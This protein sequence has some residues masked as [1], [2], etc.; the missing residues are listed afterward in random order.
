M[1]VLRQIN[2]FDLLIL[3][4]GISLALAIRF[5]LLDFKSIDYFK[6]T[7][8][9]YNTIKTN[10]FSAFSQNFSNY[11]PPYLY[12]LYLLARFFPDVP[13]LYATKIPSLIADFITALFAYLI[14]RLKYP[15]SP[16]PIFAGFAILFAPTVILNSAFWGQADALYTSVLVVSIYFV[17][18]KK[19]GLSM[20]FF[21]VSLAFK[22]QAAF[23]LPL[24][25]A[26]FLRKEISW[27]YFL[28]IP[29]I[30]F[31]ALLP[32]WVAGR[33]LIDLLLIYPS[34]A[35]QY[36]QLSMHAA[37]IFSWLPNGGRFFSYFYTA[38]LIFA[39]ATGIF[40]SIIVYNSPN[41]VQQDI[42]LELAF[43]TVLLMPFV[44]PTMHER[45]FYPADVISIIFAFYF[46][47]FFFAPILMSVVSFFSY[48]PTLFNVEPVPISVLAVCIL[49]LI[50]IISR[51]A[52]QKLFYR[53][54]K[55]EMLND[56]V[57]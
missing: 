57:K 5:S 42:L 38:G 40:Y 28:L 14:V 55:S 48:Q 49:I 31:L 41:E 43:I 50:L 4:I 17:L 52:I 11:N 29:A 20:V 30:L 21:G 7:K 53:D 33:S 2:Y 18:T 39:A 26:L 25:F 8:V 32:A 12:L 13:G 15:N 35:G 10:G 56:A 47:R 45:N 3:L 16:F 37:T 1:K 9:W 24:F 51:D 6:Y 54:P 23:I 44:L 19:Y 46:Y 36:E 27:K 22:A 34:Q